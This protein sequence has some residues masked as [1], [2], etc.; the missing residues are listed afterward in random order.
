MLTWMV[1]S[2]LSPPKKPS[3]QA[4]A[5]PK[6][7]QPLLLEDVGIN[8]YYQGTTIQHIAAAK[9]RITAKKVGLFTFKNLN[10]LTIKQLQITTYPS[11]NPSNHRQQLSST[12]IFAEVVNTF[13]QNKSAW[14]HIADLEIDNFT[15]RRIGAAGS[16]Q[17]ICQARKVDG[18]LRSNRIRLQRVRLQHPPKQQTIWAPEAFWNKARQCFD[19]PGRY[20]AQSPLG[21]AYNRGIRVGLDFTLKAL[22]PN[23]TD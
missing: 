8:K 1:V 11:R 5:L 23:T 21:T 22:P 2:S 14:G 13:G 20:R 16:I 9:I 15:W 7:R 3:P 12:A 17:V 18:D 19:I 10:A 4:G 6:Q